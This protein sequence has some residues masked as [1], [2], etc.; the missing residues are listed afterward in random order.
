MEKDPWGHEEELERSALIDNINQPIDT[1]ADGY[2]RST[3][4]KEPEWLAKFR[5]LHKAMRSIILPLD[6]CG[7]GGGTDECL[8]STRGG[9][10]CWRS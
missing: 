8:S 9:S 4:L 2:Q 5:E 10:R 7:T 1:S 3:M 6:S